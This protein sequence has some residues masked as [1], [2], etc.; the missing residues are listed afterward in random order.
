MRWRSIGND[1]AH[2]GDPRRELRVVHEHD[3]IGVVEQVAQLGFDVAVV[4]VHRDRAQLVGREDRL[5][6]RVAVEPVDADVVARADALRRK[7]M[8]EPVRPLLELRVRPRLV[9]D[10][11]RDPI[12]DGVDD[13]LGEI[14][15]VP[16]HRPPS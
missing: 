4:D 2:R 6:E 5:D 7:V 14:S 13:V 16:G 12:G 1:V 8:R 10:D 11:Q 15:D 9:G 3:E